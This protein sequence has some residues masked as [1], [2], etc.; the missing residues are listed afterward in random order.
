MPLPDLNLIRQRYKYACGYCAV[1]EVSSG[2][3]LTVDHY[4]PLA[5]GGSDDLENLVYACMRCN[6]YKHRF[7]PT[8][9]EAL[10]GFRVLHPLRD[11]LSDHYQLD[12]QTGRLEPFTVTGSFHIQ[13]LRL[14]RPQ[15]VRQR[16][17]EHIQ[18]AQT[19]RLNLLEQ[20]IVELKQTIVAQENY[21]MLLRELMG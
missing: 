10:R 16:L 11:V 15:L 2:G 18:E 5:S 9:D 12:K 4:Q 14:N 17:A 19:E 21:L 6:Q 1:T 13:L 8:P 7:W 20:Q 3:L